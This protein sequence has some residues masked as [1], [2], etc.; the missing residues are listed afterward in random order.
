MT[1]QNTDLPSTPD[2]SQQRWS[3]FRL[4]VT[5]LPINHDLKFSHILHVNILSSPLNYGNAHKLHNTL[6]PV[7]NESILRII[8]YL[9]F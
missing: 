9:I 6:Y 7:C 2:I 8:C 1:F 5:K 4:S 3:M